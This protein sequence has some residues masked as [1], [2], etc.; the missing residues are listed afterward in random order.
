MSNEVTHPP[1]PFTDADQKAMRADDIRAGTYI[2]CLAS[3]IFLVGV[4]IYTTV[5]LFTIASAPLYAIR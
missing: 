5:L 2:A 4:C 1:I 3:G